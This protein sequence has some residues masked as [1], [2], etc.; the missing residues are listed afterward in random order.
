LKNF[1]QVSYKSLKFN[2]NL[3]LH[4][5]CTSG[6]EQMQN[7]DTILLKTRLQIENYPFDIECFTEPSVPEIPI[8]PPLPK[9]SPPGAQPAKVAG[10]IKE[11]LVPVQ[12]SGSSS[13]EKIEAKISLGGAKLREPLKARIAMTWSNIYD[14]YIIDLFQLSMVT[15]ISLVF[16]NLEGN[17][18]K[19]KISL[20]AYLAH[21]PNK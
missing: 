5:I 8:P 10:S 9:V 20:Y 1:Y 15:D 7:A 3:A 16:G 12:G 2:P 14:E 17:Q 19:L 6:I 4:T 21:D 18:F 11:P 13:V